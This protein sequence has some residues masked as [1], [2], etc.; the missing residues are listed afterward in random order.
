MQGIQSQL[1]QGTVK[2]K[3]RTAKRSCSFHQTFLPSFLTPISQQPKKDVKKSLWHLH[4]ALVKSSSIK[5][6]FFGN[7]KKLKAKNPENGRKKLQLELK[8]Q[9]F[10]IFLNYIFSENI[11]L[12]IFKIH[13][14]TALYKHP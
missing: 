4:S 2:N 11:F 9:I 6:G 8:T 10:G 1:L 13:C 14:V 3:E 5:A 7:L 12:S